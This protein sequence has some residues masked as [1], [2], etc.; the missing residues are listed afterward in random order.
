MFWPLI[1][2]AAL[3]RLIVRRFDLGEYIDVEDKQ[4]PQEPGEVNI[5]LVVQRVSVSVMA[6]RFEL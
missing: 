4:R 6:S 2:E 1:G 5:A 3:K